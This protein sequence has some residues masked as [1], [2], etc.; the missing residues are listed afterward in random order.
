L[1]SG[2]YAAT[3]KTE[4]VV[5]PLEEINDLGRRYAGL[6]DGQEKENLLLEVC[7]CFHPYLMKYLVMICRGRIPVMGHGPNA[8]YINKDVKP[9][10]IYF[11][12]KGEKPTSPNLAKVARHL[13]LAFKGM[14]TEEIYDVLMEQL[15]GAVKGYDPD[16]KAKVKLVVDVINHELS[17]RKQFTV[18]DVNRHLDID[19]SRYLRLLV[20]VGFVQKIEEGYVRAGKAPG[21]G[22]AAS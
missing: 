7:Q 18:A 22:R 10:L 5:K 1:P 19:S 11:L 16:Y 17:K 15:V 6:A 21:A 13:H 3:W 14:E 2:H 4:G 9:F 20:R 8:A 12:R